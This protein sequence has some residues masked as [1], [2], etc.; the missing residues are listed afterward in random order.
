MA[1]RNVFGAASL[2]FPGQ[3]LQTRTSRW[4]ANPPQQDY[5]VYQNRNNPR[6]VRFSTGVVTY[7]RLRGT[8]SDLRFDFAHRKPS[9]ANPIVVIC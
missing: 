8:W 2:I 4:T 1:R 7:D 9:V 5:P 6:R 3:N